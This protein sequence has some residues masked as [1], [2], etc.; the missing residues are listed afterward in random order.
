MF[1]AQTVD[2]GIA[3]QEMNK[4]KMSMASAMEGFGKDRQL[5]STE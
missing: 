4:Y 3:K 5:P 1:P 2:W